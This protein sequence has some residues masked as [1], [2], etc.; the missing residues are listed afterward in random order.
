MIIYLLEWDVDEYYA[1]TV[2]LINSLAFAY[3][4][5]ACSRAMEYKDN[6]PSIIKYDLETHEVIQYWTDIPALNTEIG[7]VWLIKEWNNV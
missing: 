6:M 3:I 4:E 5:D 1:S 7:A 2:Q